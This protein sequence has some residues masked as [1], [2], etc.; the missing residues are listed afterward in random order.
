MF[1]LF[2]KTIGEVKITHISD[3][4]IHYSLVDTKNN[5]VKNGV[6]NT[7]V[8]AQEEAVLKRFVHQYVIEKYNK[9]YKMHEIQNNLQLIEQLENQK[10][11]ISTI[12]S[13][14]RISR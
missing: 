9:K 3:K 2:K 12:S 1:G 6:I 11:Q 7:Q 13:S 8:N 5:V 4:D 10:H 14:Y